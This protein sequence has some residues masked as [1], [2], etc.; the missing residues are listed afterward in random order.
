VGKTVLITGTSSGI[1]KDTALYFATKGW[2]VVATMRNPESRETDLKNRNG[3]DCVHLDVLD[4]ESIRKAIRFAKDK[5]ASIDVIVNNA[6]YATLG[7]FEASKREQVQKQFNTNVIGLMDITKEIIPVFREQG[8]GTIINVASMGGR[9]SFPF[10]SVY[11]ATKWAV[12]GFSESLQ[13]ELRPFNIRV[14]IIEPGVIETDFYGR[15]MDT[16][17][18]KNAET[19]DSYLQSSKKKMGSMKGSRPIVVAE[20]IFRAANDKS[21]RLRYTAGSDARLLLS[22]RKLAPDQLFFSILR[23]QAF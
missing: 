17:Q 21:W 5:H 18:D 22:I 3:V 11:N 6:G 10:Y 7:P 15:S 1:G 13:Y 12:E 19:Y 14:K 2:S 16:F 4:P 23:S 8:H 20:T 9:V